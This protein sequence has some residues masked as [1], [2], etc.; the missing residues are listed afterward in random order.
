MLGMVFIIVSG[1]LGSFRLSWRYM[2]TL[3]KHIVAL[4]FVGIV[5]AGIVGVWTG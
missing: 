3:V 4:A 2:R 5:I 1:V